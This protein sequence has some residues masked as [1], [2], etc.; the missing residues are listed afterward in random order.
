MS[1]KIFIKNLIKNNC[2]FA[3]RCGGHSYEPAS[4]SNNYIIDVSKF[5]NIKIHKKYAIVGSG[6]KLGDLINVL[7][8]NKKITAT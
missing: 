3:L 6:I 7:K 1:N 5:N 4:L 2:S 8:I